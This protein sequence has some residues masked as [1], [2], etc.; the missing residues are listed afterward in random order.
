MSV[1]ALVSAK[2]S[3]GVTTTALALTWAWPTVTGGRGVL[4]I[5]ADVAGSGIA[6]GLL[7]TAPV[8]GGLT[9]LAAERTPLDADTLLAAAVPLDREAARLVLLGVTDPAQAR[10]LPGLWAPLAHTARDLHPRGMDVL[11][12]GGRLG[13][14]GEALPLLEHADLT[15]LVTGSGLVALAAARPALRRLTLLRG[16]GRAVVVLLVGEHRPYTATEI[17]TALGVEVVAV[18]AHDPATATALT[19]GSPGRPR[20]ALTRTARAAAT[21]LATRAAGGTTRP[22]AGVPSVAVPRTAD[23]EGVRR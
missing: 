23:L 1:I 9:V 6:P 12:D 11:I 5:D 4:V 22:D 13:S 15:V 20:S 14:T 8:E 18:L 19:G 3:P 10:A 2:G 17:T 16:P 7:G 21:H